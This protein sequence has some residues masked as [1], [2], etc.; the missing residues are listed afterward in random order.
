MTA[1]Q[2]KSF[3]DI[4]GLSHVTFVVS[5]LD[6]MSKF[7][8]R[9]FDAR[10]VYASGDRTFSLSAEKFFLV[11]GIWIAIMEGD[12]QGEKSYNHI[13]F[14]IKDEQF[15]DYAKRIR[16]LGVKIR[17]ARQ[18]KAGEGRSLYFY[19]YD[20]HLFELHTGTLEKRL[21]SYKIG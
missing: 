10:E 7:M 16:S 11:G 8:S 15:D 20:N 3:T 1:S 12:V 4:G 5:D 17:E 9:I 21:E 18:R 2:D 19:D 14:K 6:R 13:A